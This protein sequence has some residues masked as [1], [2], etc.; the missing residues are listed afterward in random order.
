MFVCLF[1]PFLV[2]TQNLLVRERSLQ[3][4]ALLKYLRKIKPRKI[5]VLMGIENSTKVVHATE[6]S[7]NRDFQILLI[8]FM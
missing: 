5:Q 7:A 4:Q 6:L 3:L 1:L 2:I 8:R